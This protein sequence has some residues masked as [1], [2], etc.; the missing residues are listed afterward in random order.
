MSW[1]LKS[2]ILFLVFFVIDSLGNSS[3][4]NTPSVLKKIRTYWRSDYS[5]KLH[6][7]IVLFSYI[8]VGSTY[9]LSLGMYGI[10]FGLLFPLLITLFYKKERKP[11][12]FNTYLLFCNYA[13]N[14]LFYSLKS[15]SALHNFTI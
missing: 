3:K 2:L 13:T 14:L 15:A 6:W 1:F 10:I 12:I 11:I 9:D 4:E 5:K 7:K 8:L